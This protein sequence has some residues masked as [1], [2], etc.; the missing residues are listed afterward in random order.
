M[1][2]KETINAKFVGDPADDFA[3]PS[4]ISM[5]GVDF[6][7]G[8]YVEVTDAN[9][10]RKIRGHSHFHV[11][12]EGEVE[13]VHTE[14]DDLPALGLE[15]LKDLARAEG[16]EFQEDTTKAKLMKAVRAKR[17]ADASA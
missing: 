13:A 7:K 10:I 9:A 14:T 1:D 4:N 17:A 11:E 12:G 15:A 2:D 3:G 5:F 8:E 6:T 16:V